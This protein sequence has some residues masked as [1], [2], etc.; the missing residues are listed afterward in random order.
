MQ[1]KRAVL[2][3]VQSH[4][5][6]VLDFK[7]NAV[8]VIIGGNNV[9]KSVLGKMIRYATTFD[10]YPRKEIDALIRTGEVAA[11]MQLQFFNEENILNVKIFPTYVLTWWKG[12]SYKNNKGIPPEVAKELGFF[13]ARNTVLNILG[14]RQPIPIVEQDDDMVAEIIKELLKHPEIESM[15]KITEEELAILQDVKRKSVQEHKILSRSFSS[16][17]FV[18]VDIMEYENNIRKDLQKIVERM[19]VIL[20]PDNILNTVILTGY[21]GDVG[22]LDFYQNHYDLLKVKEPLLIADSE[23]DV[24][25]ELFKNHLN[26]IS[27]VPRIEEYPVNV[28]LVLIK[29]LE[30]LLDISG[31]K[32]SENQERILTHKD[33][34]SMLLML[35]KLKINENKQ[36]ALWAEFEVCPY[37]GNDIKRGMLIG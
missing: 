31:L 17:K 5:H 24:N 36:K 34:I 1:I 12:V 8:N 2:V 33:L 28:N 16:S 22:E 11:E 3:N 10:L 32:N 18:E 25:I 13:S 14:D 21:K 23:V 7:E 6:T 19:T 27:T 9:G 30:D 37:C 35:N 20:N 15:L 29:I 26:F 4:K